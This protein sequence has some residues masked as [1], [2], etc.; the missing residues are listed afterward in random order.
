[1]GE[2]ELPHS[3]TTSEL[4]SYNSPQSIKKPDCPSSNALALHHSP[5]RCT[6]LTTLFC[7]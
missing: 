2:L 1:M 7:S 4:T 6:A 3:C 5:S